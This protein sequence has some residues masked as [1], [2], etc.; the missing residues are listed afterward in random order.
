MSQAYE[1]TSVV[2]LYVSSVFSRF[3][4]TVFSSFLDEL[5]EQFSRN[6][7]KIINIFVNLQQQ[8]S[9][10]Y[11]P[12]KITSNLLIKDGQFNPCLV[13]KYIEDIF[14][15]SKQDKL[16]VSTQNTFSPFKITLEMS[17]KKLIVKLLHK[18]TNP[19]IIIGFRANKNA[20]SFSSC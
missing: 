3:T 12:L 10:K 14:S 4:T 15:I 11:V 16:S 6:F 20:I 17:V 7:I 19:D 5:K 8:K 18:I 2:R 1:N 13:L 9:Q